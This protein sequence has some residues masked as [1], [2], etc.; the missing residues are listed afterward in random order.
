MGCLDEDDEEMLK[1]LWSSVYAVGD[2][3]F[4]KEQ[5]AWAIQEAR[6]RRKSVDLE[7]PERKATPLEDIER[8]V[9]KEFGVTV[10]RLSQKGASTG[11]GRTVLVELC[12]SAGC[13]AQR[14]MAVRLGG[15]S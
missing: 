7:L 5:E 12:C 8:L 11:W 14:A 3:E 6:R 2:E 13:L 4:R 9:G 10:E 15:V 1:A